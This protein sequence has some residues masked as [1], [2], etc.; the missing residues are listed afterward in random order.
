MPGVADVCRCVWCVLTC[1]ALQSSSWSSTS[2]A[3]SSCSSSCSVLRSLS[4][5]CS[6]ASLSCSDW[7]R[8]AV[9]LS[10]KSC[11]R[12]LPIT[13]QLVNDTVGLQPL[14]DVTQRL[15]DQSCALIY[16]IIRCLKSLQ[17]VCEANVSSAANS[18]YRCQRYQLLLRSSYQYMRNIIR[19][20]RLHNICYF[21]IEAKRFNFWSTTNRSSRS[22][23]LLFFDMMKTTES[24]S[25]SHPWSLVHEAVC[26][27]WSCSGWVSPCW[28]GGRPPLWPAAGSSDLPAP[29]RPSPC[30]A[31]CRPALPA[32]W[33]QM[34]F[35]WF[36]VSSL[37]PL[38]MP[39]NICKHLYNIWKHM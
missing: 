6:R 22:F 17:S 26:L 12:S 19:Y 4:T 27:T 24:Q 30:P 35:S 33:Q 7:L 34:W 10:R 25:E 3:R 32:P 1:V 5:C 2:C 31:P 9:S 14:S 21:S 16:I 20:R 15:Q 8:R 18:V 23:Y 38:Y 11:S 37:L 28:R 13:E 36:K 39:G 29:G